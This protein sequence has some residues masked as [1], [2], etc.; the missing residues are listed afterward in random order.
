MSLQKVN[1]RAK[2]SYRVVGKV[3]SVICR[4]EMRE[5]REA[6]EAEKQDTGSEVRRHP[7]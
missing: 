6:N 3:I 1:L 4:N 5:P 2:V 7:G